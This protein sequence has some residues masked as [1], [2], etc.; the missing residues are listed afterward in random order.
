MS[1][2]SEVISKN[3]LYYKGERITQD[4]LRKFCDFLKVMD[5]LIR[6]NRCRLVIRLPD[7]DDVF[8]ALTL[9]NVLVNVGECVIISKRKDTVE[10]LL[11]NLSTLFSDYYAIFV[12]TG[13][14]KIYR[15][16]MRD[17]LEDGNPRDILIFGHPSNTDCIEE[18]HSSRSRRAVLILTGVDSLDEGAEV[19]NLISA[20]KRAG[21]RILQ[22]RS[23]KTMVRE[24]N[25]RILRLHTGHFREFF[26]LKSALNQEKH[27]RYLVKALNFYLRV[28]VPLKMYSKYVRSLHV[29]TKYLIDLPSRE[30]RMLASIKNDSELGNLAENLSKFEEIIWSRNPKYEA[31]IRII[32]SAYR[33]GNKVPLLFPNRTFSE[34]F[35]MAIREDPRLSDRV[36]DTVQP[37]YRRELA[38]VKQTFRALLLTCIPTPELLLRASILSNELVLPVY[39]LETKYLERLLGLVNQ[40]NYFGDRHS[41]SIMLKIKRPSVLD[42]RDDHDTPAEEDTFE[43]PSFEDYISLSRIFEDSREETECR[44]GVALDTSSYII[45]T[46]DGWGVTVK[47]YEKVLRRTSR[48]IFIEDSLEWVPPA[49]LNPGDTVI[50]IDRG[51]LKKLL[52]RELERLLSEDVIESDQFLQLFIGLVSM[53]KKHLYEV[54]KEFSRAEIHRILQENGLKRHYGTV[55]HWFFGLSPDPVESVIVSLLNPEI[56]IGPQSK[57]DIIIFARTFGFNE[58]HECAEQVYNAMELFRA[59]NRKTG[60]LVR[61]KIISMILHGELNGKYKTSRV[62]EVVRVTENE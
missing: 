9:V 2:I 44:R 35:K 15:N 24:V 20:L 27:R 32:D 50:Y 55:N 52:K 12:R 14:V 26:K 40:T 53:W 42:Y 61:K 5:D 23:P 31:I 62:K 37:L 18:V 4:G 13:R 10:E 22:F 33:R 56:N 16:Y 28:P 60:K 57:D 48:T 51:V 30:I 36:N 7:F 19:L 46:V 54:G 59:L 41:L 43:I 34:A 45:K 38:G 49:E 21:W 39:G 1:G 8:S 11:S 47:G 29:S 25:L 6:N 17:I 58:L 3:I